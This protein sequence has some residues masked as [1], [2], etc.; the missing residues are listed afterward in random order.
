MHIC[1]FALSFL[2]PRRVNLVW[3]KRKLFLVPKVC[4]EMKFA[5]SEPESGDK[6]WSKFVNKTFTRQPEKCVCVVFLPGRQKE[7]SLVQT[8]QQFLNLIL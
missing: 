4:P 8:Q 5:K 1:V 3:S 6:L 2:K 7:R